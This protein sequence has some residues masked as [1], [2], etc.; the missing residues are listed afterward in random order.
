MFA[1]VDISGQQMKV[2]SGKFVY[3]NRIAL[4]E[5]AGLTLDK[6]L[7]VENNGSTRIGQ[8]F[9]AGASVKATVL[10]H[11]RDDK[12]IVFKKKKR[13]GYKVKR[14]HR[15]HLTQLRIEAISA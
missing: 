5:G 10:R 9:V 15:Q 7:L 2:E 8:P 3:V 11:V 14:G 13:K 6:V 1:I 12:V 4:E